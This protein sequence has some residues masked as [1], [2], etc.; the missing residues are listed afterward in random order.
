MAKRFGSFSALTDVHLSIQPAEIHALVGQNGSGKSTLI[1]VL[2][3]YHVPDRGSRLS[4]DGQPVHLPVR[5]ASLHAAGISV[6]HQDLG[7]VDWLSVAE[8]ISIGDETPSALTRKLDRRREA[9]VARQ[10]L[11]KLHVGVDPARPAGSLA[12]EERASVAIARAMRRQVPGKGLII[13]DESTRALSAEAAATFYGT[14]R[15][16]VRRGSSVL[17]VAHSLPEVMRVADRVTVLRDGRVV[18]AGLPTSELSE[19]DLARLMLGTNLEQAGGYTVPAG[20]PTRISVSG[21]RSRHPGALDFTVAQGEIVGLT[22]P[23]G[24]GWEQ[25][26]YLL[27]GVTPAAAGSLTVDGHSH[28]LTCAGVRQLLRA[29]VA[30]VPERRDT[31]GL[32]HG[33]TLT[34]NVTLP[35]LRKRG[36]SL[37]TGVSWQRD[38]AAQT[39]CDF[40]VRPADPKLPVGK[41]S[42]GN[43]QKVLFSKWLLDGPALLLL[44]EPTQGVDVAARQVLLAA[45]GSAARSGVSVVVVS[46]DANE[47]S[48]VCH[49]VLIV[50][51]GAITD[52]LTQ[53]DPD[54]IVSAVYEGEL[55]MGSL[56]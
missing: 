32:A 34:E 55:R 14:L 36:R 8:N 39:I 42:G 50:R 37:F 2:T 12:P 11:A 35:R 51:D 46:I 41:L 47:L 3:G 9:A 30:V 43:Q 22:G 40:G 7:L 54:D 24:G 49:R 29:G 15:H 13:L 38:E 6:V 45:I 17:V 4:V 10:L 26:P 44:H 1:K 16:A 33:L 25:V 56:T 52:E 5:P 23:V 18:G 20:G 27:A 28:D 19:Q 31:Q 53:P 21:L 48:A